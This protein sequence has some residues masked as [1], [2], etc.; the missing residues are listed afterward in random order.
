ME[1]KSSPKVNIKFI[2]DKD[3]PFY[4]HTFEKEE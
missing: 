4:R 3:E 2:F 1:D